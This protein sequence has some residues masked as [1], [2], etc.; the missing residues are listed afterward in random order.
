[1]ITANLEAQIAAGN[2]VIIVYGP[3]QAGKTT[4]VNSVLRQTTYKTLSINADK[5][6][7]SDILSSRDSQKLLRLCEG[8]DLIFIDEA[9]RIPD[10][11]I[12]IK[13]LHE[14]R[15]KLRIILTGSSSLELAGKAK[16]PL[17]G[18]T[19]T[20]TLL[21]ISTSELRNHCPPHELESSLEDHLRFGLYPELLQQKT[22]AD[23]IRY[24]TEL[25]SA[26]LYK[27]ILELSGIKHASKLGDLLRLLALQIGSEV[28]IAELGTAL[29]LNRS[30]VDSYLDL[31]EQSFVI[32]RI[33]G[34]SR[35]LRKE[36]SKMDKIYFYDLGIRNILIENV[37]AMD[38]RTD[39]G[40]LW[41]NHLMT[42][43]KKLLIYSNALGSQYFWR[44]NTGA[45]LDCV[46]HINGSLHGYEF[47]WKK[48]TEKAPKS[49]TETYQ[50]KFTCISK[51][52]YLD[53]IA[54]APIPESGL[55]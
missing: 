45:E 29:G 11:G 42:E 9:Q 40:A 41:E 46:E 49:W 32:Y 25:S 37:N 50:A 38:M 14:E 13:I 10:I 1:M 47:K 15:P 5:V 27:D 16:E 48:R 55:Q 7:Y 21:P 34:F 36:V 6:S 28:S 4:L 2:K 44:T 19:C 12:N 51:D 54:A 52:N 31:L 17:T 22:I 30:T 24:L 33:S 53:Y 43:R 39:T 35:N 18:R 3:R 8:Y 23:K 26:Y 20:Y